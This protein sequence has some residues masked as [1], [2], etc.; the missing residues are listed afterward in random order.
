M[1]ILVFQMT[2]CIHKVDATW[3]LFGQVCM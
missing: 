3:N 2:F 1:F